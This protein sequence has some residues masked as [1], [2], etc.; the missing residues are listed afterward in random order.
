VSA[1]EKKKEMRKA[2]IASRD[3]LPTERRGAASDAITRRVCALRRFR[4]A[5]RIALFASLPGEVDTAGL[6][7][8]AAERDAET[9]Y[10][11][12]ERGEIAFYP[13]RRA[14]MRAGVW[15][16]LEPAGGEPVAPSTVDLFVVPGLAFDAERRRLGFGRGYYDRALAK[17]GSAAKLAVAFDLQIVDEVPVGPDDVAMDCVVTETRIFAGGPG[18]D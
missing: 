1:G 5:K 13:A 4:A 6:E 9:V 15:G 2:M 11:K 16:I 17:A 10:P 7:R 3:A 14:A 12:V 18:W 8:A